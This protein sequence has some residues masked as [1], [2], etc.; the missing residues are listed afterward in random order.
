MKALIVVFLVVVT[1]A[2]V[3]PQRHYAMVE[4]SDRVVVVYCK[5]G[6]QPAVL[7]SK[8]HPEVLPMGVMVGCR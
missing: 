8:D 6:T 7:L 1:A 4:S 2:A 5:D 3:S